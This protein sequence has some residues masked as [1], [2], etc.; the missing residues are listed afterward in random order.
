MKTERR[1]RI[2]TL[3]FWIH[4][5]R[6]RFWRLLAQPLVVWV[7]V[8]LKVIHWTSHRRAMRFQKALNSW[9]KRVNRAMPELQ[10]L[11]GLT[12]ARRNKVL[13][14]RSPLLDESKQLQ[15]ALQTLRLTA[16]PNSF[17]GV[18]ALLT[19]ISKLS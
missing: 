10:S 11:N 17:A 13:T 9:K 18:S 6:S 1:V 16:E 8:E 14:L 15:D 2:A 5:I 4:R 12:E 19:G 7:K 3:V